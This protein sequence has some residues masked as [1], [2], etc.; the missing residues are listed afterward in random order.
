MENYKNYLKLYSNILKE[1]SIILRLLDIGKC[2]SLIDVRNIISN[3]KWND[4]NKKINIYDFTKG[5]ITENCS[6]FYSNILIK[7][8]INIIQI[9]KN[10]NFIDI[11]LEGTINKNLIVF[12]CNVC[13]SENK[14][15]GNIVELNKNILTINSELQDFELSYIIGEKI[16]IELNIY[17]VQ[18]Y[19]KGVCVYLPVIKIDGDNWAYDCTVDKKTYENDNKLCFNLLDDIN[20]ANACGILSIGLLGAFMGKIT[21]DKFQEK[22][23]ENNLEDKKILI[24]ILNKVKKLQKNVI[25]DIDTESESETDSDSDSGSDQNSNFKSEED[26]KLDHD[27]SID[28]DEKEYL[29]EIKREI[30]ENNIENNIKNIEKS[31][32][33]LPSNNELNHTLMNLQNLE[34]NLDQNLEQ[35]ISEF[36]EI[37]NKIKI[38]DSINFENEL[39]NSNIEYKKYQE[40]EDMS[41]IKEAEYYINLLNMNK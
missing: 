21:Y 19:N 11:V 30:L 33:D 18:N 15:I 8:D 35:N 12:G 4:K 31:I 23:D 1:K 14:K 38:D 10:N 25:S 34:E 32:K 36:E 13:I 24:D 2:N 29:K 20:P 41:K 6:L 26:V 17:A 7:T 16:L 37:Y 5:N 40:S 28:F 39:L 22:K 27:S 3:C 9:K